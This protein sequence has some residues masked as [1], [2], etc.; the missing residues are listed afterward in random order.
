ML[1]VERAAGY[2][3]IWTRWVWFECLS[4]RVRGHSDMF[5]FSGDSRG[6]ESRQVPAGTESERR[7]SLP[8]F[9]F[10]LT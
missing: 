10:R 7:P 5:V 8:R 2:G 1:G 3:R 6:N 4:G 9:S